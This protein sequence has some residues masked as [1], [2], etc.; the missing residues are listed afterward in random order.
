MLGMSATTG[1]PLDGN[2]HLAQSVGDIL[3]T[4]LGSQVMRRDYGSMLFD[5][6]DQPLNAATR[7]LF[8]GATAM[9]LA[10]WEPRLRLRK[11]AISAGN[12]AGELTITLDGDRTDL[13]ANAHVLLSVPIRTGGLSTA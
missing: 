9:A 8:Y 2:D 3:S 6:I 10:R 4:P 1:K 7:L 11:V 13:T 5:L 12:A